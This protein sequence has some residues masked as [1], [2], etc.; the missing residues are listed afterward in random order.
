MHGGAPLAP[1]YL[2]RPDLRAA[3]FSTDADGTR[4]FHTDDVGHRDGVGRW[5]VDGRLDDLV[6]TG[7]LKVAPRV[8]EDALT[9]VVPGVAEAVVVGL[10]DAEWGQVVAAALVLS[11]GA[12]PPTLTGAREALR[13]TLPAHALPRHLL[14]LDALPLRGPGKPDRLA[15]TN[16]LEADRAARATMEA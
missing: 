14:V 7:G 15:V 13:G 1:G 6:N 10:P 5:H 12:D 9:E 11:P 3:P 16:L 4:W 2:G 8:V